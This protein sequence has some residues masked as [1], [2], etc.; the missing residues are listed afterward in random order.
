[1]V[2]SINNILKIGHY[3]YSFKRKTF[4]Y[5][6]S[7]NG[8]SLWNIFYKKEKKNYFWCEESLMACNKSSH[9]TFLFIGRQVVFYRTSDIVS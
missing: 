2:M 8:K 4:L 5:V 6:L 9:C 7:D 3:I 1:M